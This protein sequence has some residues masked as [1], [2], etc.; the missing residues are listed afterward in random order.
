MA[1]KKGIIA[2]MGSGELT[3]T[4]VEVHKELLSGFPDSPKAV[5][6]DTPAGFELNADQ[7]SQR[8]VDYFQKHVHQSLAVAHY[9]NKES[10]SDYDAA[11]S[12]QQ[13]READFILIGPGSPTYAVR[14]WQQTPIPE[15]MAEHLNK[16]GCLVAA[17]AAALT[18]GRYTLPVY[19]IYKVGE[20]LHWVGGM[21]IPGGFGLNLV[22]IPHWNNAEG[23]THDTR[24]CYMGEDRLK[25]LESLLPEEVLILGLDEH[26]ACLLDLEKESASVKGLGNVTLHRGDRERVFQKGE[27]F[28][29]DVLRK[30]EAGKSKILREKEDSAPS[31]VQAPVKE[32]FWERVHA[33]ED[34]FTTALD[35]QEAK[36][37]INALLELDQ[38]IW[39]GQQDSESQEFISQ[40]REFYREMIVALG[41]NYESLP[42][43]QADCLRP[44]VDSL[45]GLREQFRVEKNYGAADAIR[46]VLERAGIVVEDGREGSRWRLK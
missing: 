32:A 40:A 8:A 16:G 22:I 46:Q 35:Q 38:V 3:G 1:Q 18:L 15:I 2:L 43:S 6:L 5:F 9:K 39:R 24:F 34:L 31:T 45:L 42:K 19:E 7:I 37:V 30:G 20:D 21:N 36:N 12:F 33:L 14:Q 29:L 17:S 44:L 27:T 41:V 4:M 11:L 28:P 10:I 23:G 13:L 25:K 26:T